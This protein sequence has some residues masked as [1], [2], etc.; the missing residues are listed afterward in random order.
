MGNGDL[1]FESARQLVRL[2]PYAW[3]GLVAI[4]ALF[5]VLARPA[6]SLAT[7]AARLP[8][9][10]YRDAPWTERARM[11]WPSRRL[12]SAAALILGG[13]SVVAFAGLKSDSPLFAEFRPDDAGDRRW[14]AGNHPLHDRQ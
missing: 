9:R 7:T 3:G 8:L 14:F 4:L 2:S 10:R 5:Y 11:A 12:G 1:A 6:T 13:L